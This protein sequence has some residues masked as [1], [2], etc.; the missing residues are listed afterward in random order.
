LIPSD[1]DRLGMVSRLGTSCMRAAADGSLINFLVGAAGKKKRRVVLLKYVLLECESYVRCTWRAFAVCLS[2]LLSLCAFEKGTQDTMVEEDRNAL[3]I[4]STVRV[5]SRV[6]IDPPGPKRLGDDGTTLKVARRSIVATLPDDDGRISLVQDDLAPAPRVGGGRFLIAPMFRSAGVHVDECE[7]VASDVLPLLAFEERGCGDDVDD[8]KDCGDQL[9]RLNDYTCAT[10]YYEAALGLVSTKVE[11]GGTVV[12][13]RKGHCV[14]AEV[15]SIEDD[16]DNNISFDVAFPSGED[17]ATISQK[18]I[19]L[20]VWTKDVSNLQIKILLNL[21][22]CLL[23]LADIDVHHG[24]SGHF[25]ETTSTSTAKSD[26]QDRYRQATVLGCSIALSIC[27][28]RASESTDDESSSELNVLR[29]KA[30]IVRSRAF[31]AL[32]K[33]PNA[34]VDVR[35]VLIQNASNRE[36]KGMLSEIKAAEARV[37]L[38]DKRL[39]KEFCRWIKTA[40]DTSNGSRAL[41]RVD[42][43]VS[44]DDQS[45]DVVRDGC[46][47]NHTNTKTIDR[48]RVVSNIRMEMCALALLLV[49]IFVLCR[50]DPQY[51]SRLS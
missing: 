13:R 37:K 19:L 34:T 8:C 5:T 20:A 25:G 1:A 39:S 26:R 45:G 9:L 24:S 44:D 48:W 51:Y 4:G 23:K 35:K 27:D 36:A 47:G 12:L 3:P 49:S 31:L 40:T 7:A 30:R 21:S 32:R 41:G 38:T 16:G 10:S 18:E 46:D 2:S 6:V 28:H 43:L 17:D 15:D 29:E 14:I 42:D 11:V 50:N 22:R 33:L